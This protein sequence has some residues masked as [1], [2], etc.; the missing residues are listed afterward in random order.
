MLNKFISFSMY[1]KILP[2]LFVIFLAPNLADSQEKR[3]RVRVIL[4][5]QIGYCT[6]DND[7]KATGLFNNPNSNRT[8]LSFGHGL[9]IGILFPKQ[10][11]ISVKYSQAIIDQSW[12]VNSNS[13]FT[14]FGY[15]EPNVV[16]KMH[17]ITIK[18]RVMLGFT[19]HHLRTDKFSTYFSVNAGVMHLQRT[20]QIIGGKTTKTQGYLPDA[21]LALGLSYLFTPHIG[22]NA[23]VGIGGG[24]PF[25]AGLVVRI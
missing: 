12:A 19:W 6:S 18:K 8:D 22:F 3:E 24:P 15:E 17:A 23:E 4:N 11:G 9:E 2:Y 20:K 14:L 10:F 5:P 16:T 1:L 25:V 7:V 13:G 21:R